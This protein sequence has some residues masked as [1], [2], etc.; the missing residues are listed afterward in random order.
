MDDK[1]ERKLDDFYARPSR[2]QR[3]RDWLV[4]VLTEFEFYAAVALGAAALRRCGPC[5][6]PGWPYS[7]CRRW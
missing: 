5:T 7:H 4:F 2:L 6:G 1:T 3:P